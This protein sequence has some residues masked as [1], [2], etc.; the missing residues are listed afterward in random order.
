M[1][2]AFRDRIQVASG[3]VNILHSYVTYFYGASAANKWCQ[4]IPGNEATL[5]LDQDGNWTGEWTTENDDMNDNLFS[6]DMGFNIDNIALVEH[7]N[8]RRTVFT[9]D[10]AS[11]RSFHFGGSVQS[12]NSVDD[13][14]QDTEVTEQP[15]SA[16]EAPAHAVAPDAT[17]AALAIGLGE[18]G[19]H[20]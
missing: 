6:E 9:T 1:C 2:T 8:N 20:T 17:A 7:D 19:H 18:G 14:V 3:I 11:M 12:T 15:G 13:A 16:T 10:D 5:T 4:S